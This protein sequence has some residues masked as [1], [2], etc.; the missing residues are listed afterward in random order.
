MKKKNIYFG[1]V[2]KKYR[3]THSAI[4]A[5]RV[6]LFFSCKRLYQR[7]R[8]PPRFALFVHPKTQNGG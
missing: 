6:C 2:Y 3:H 1:Y 8:G 4:E 5:G 7:P